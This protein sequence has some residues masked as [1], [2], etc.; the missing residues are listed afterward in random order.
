LFRSAARE[1]ILRGTTQ[2]RDAVRVTLGLKSKPVLTAGDDANSASPVVRPCAGLI[3]AGAD[4]NLIGQLDET[5]YRVS[6][7]PGSTEARTQLLADHMNALEA[8]RAAD[9]ERCSNGASG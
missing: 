8:S 5:P 1:K 3:L 9:A 2:L 6:G 7:D 4:G